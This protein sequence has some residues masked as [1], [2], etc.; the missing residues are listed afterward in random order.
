MSTRP[1]PSCSSGWNLKGCIVTIDAMGCQK[2]IAERIVAKG[3]D[4]V[5]A[6]KEN[7]PHRHEA[8][9]DSFQTAKVAQFQHVPASCCEHLDAGHGCYEVRRSWLV[10]DLSTL[11]NPHTWVNL[12]RIGMLESECHHGEQ[13]SHECRYYITALEGEEVQALRKRRA[14]PTGGGLRIGSTGS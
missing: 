14:W 8:I 7:Q 4:S 6:V 5:L 12:R 13:I 11:P 9:H 3:A 10:N 2:V 1:S